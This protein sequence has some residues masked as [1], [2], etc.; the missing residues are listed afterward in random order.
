MEI[1]VKNVMHIPAN[2]S[3]L[4]SAIA[5]DKRWVHS[6]D[7]NFEPTTPHDRFMSG[8]ARRMLESKMTGVHV[9]DLETLEQAEYLLP[10][11]DMMDDLARIA[12]GF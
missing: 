6:Q 9:K 12:F 1:R 8:N 11:E 7:E 10:T 3:A 2:S 4:D 5:R